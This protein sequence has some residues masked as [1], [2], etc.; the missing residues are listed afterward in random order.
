MLDVDPTNL[1]ALRALEA[2]YEKTDQSEKYLE[3]LEAQLDASPSDA[4][5]VSLYERMAAAWEERFG[6]LDRA[7]E[8]L[9]KIVAIDSRNYSAYRELARLYQQAGK[10]EALVETYRNHIM[11]TADVADARRPLRRDGRGLRGAARRHRSRDRG[12]QRRPRLRRRR[13]ARARRA[14]PPVRE[15]QRV[16]S[17]DRRDEPPRAAHRGPR[18]QVD[19]YCADG[20][21]PVRPARATPMRAEANLL[22]GL[23]LDPAHVPTMEA[24]TK[25]Y[26]DRGDWLKAAQMMVRAESYTPVAIDKVRLLFEA[27]NIYQDKLR[28]DEP[29]KQLYAAVIA[30]DPEHVEAGRPLAELYFEAQEWAQLSPVID[31]LA[32]KV[33]AAARRPA[34]AQRAVL[35]RGEDG[36]RARR[37]PARRSA[38]TRTPTTSTRRICRR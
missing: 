8:A 30:L 29:A 33:G 16:G 9:E 12:V 5:H 2:L 10:W 17:R 20:P 37:L 15:D 14:R 19:L 34:R 38:T 28:Q 13:A 22:R 31:M 1:T 36:R 24:L 6:K 3:V 32:R 35:P 21:H 4:E 7:A 18:K 27:A 26:S 25:Q 11:A 23:A